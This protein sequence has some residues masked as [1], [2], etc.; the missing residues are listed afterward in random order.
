M[1]WG[2]ERE[3]YGVHLSLFWSVGLTDYVVLTSGEGRVVGNGEGRGY[4][5]LSRL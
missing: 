5:L 4:L 2:R 1:I 3:G